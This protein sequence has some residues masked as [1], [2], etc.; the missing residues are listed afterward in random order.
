MSQSTITIFC[1]VLGQA[2]G[3]G[4]LAWYRNW[5]DNRRE[6]PLE[7][8]NGV[9]VPDGKLKRW[10]RRARVGILTWCAL[11][12]VGAVLFGMFVLSPTR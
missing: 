9:W 5:R 1:M 11:S 7:L 10:E 8:Q 2:I 4:T 6:I 12:L 3:F